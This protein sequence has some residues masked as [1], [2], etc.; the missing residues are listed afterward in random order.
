MNNSKKIAFMQKALEQAKKALKNNEVPIGAIVIDSAG[1]I[2]GR[3][4]NQVEKK[5]TQAAHAECLAIAQAVKKIGNWRLNGSW[6][7]VTL[8]PCLMCFGLIQLSRI[9]G[10][11]FGAKSTLFGVGLDKIETLPFY[12]KN[13]AV[14][15]NI[16]EKECLDLLQ[17]FFSKVRK[18]RKKENETTIKL[19]GKNQN[20]T[21]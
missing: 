2:I 21:A 4:Y 14:E 8:E 1:S 10:L 19:F 20:K 15:G 17:V 3:G 9:E 18:K 7:Y 11:A 6:I 12:T 13:I 16:L 5:Q